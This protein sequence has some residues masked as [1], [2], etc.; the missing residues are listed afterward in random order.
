MLDKKMLTEMIASNLAP[1]LE[2]LDDKSVTE[3]MINPGGRVF[4]EA[5]GVLSA[6][7]VLISDLDVEKTIIAVGKYAG[8][9]PRRDSAAGIV[10]ASI[11]D[12]RF[13]GALPPVC[14][15]GSFISIRK[16]SDK[17][18]RPSMENL[19]A[20]NML[21][22]EQ[23]ERLEDLV[24]NQRKNLF[25]V[26]GTGSGKTT[27]LNAL[28][29]RLPAYERVLTIE[30]SRE[31][32][33]ELE[34]HFPMVANVD[35]GITARDLVKLMLRVRPDRLVLG[36]TRGDETYD[37]IRAFNSGHPGS[38]STIH[39]DSAEQGLAALEMMFQMSLPENARMS[40]T[41]MRQCIAASVNVVVFV[42]RSTV[43][44]DGV[45]KVV[46]KVTEICIVK[47]VVDGKYVLE[48]VA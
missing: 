2:W 34:N 47:G 39:A 33:L 24:L 40:D 22:Q 14:P 20:W 1:I 15:D 4:V 7:G 29:N 11:D 13:S 18:E 37:V 42:S 8:K 10:Y 9:N 6:K 5:A 26:G 30:D 38:I 48:N 46:R 3:I 36:E 44:K 43:K 41:V 19:I 25:I 16:H 31:I 23:A 28:L 35:K 21:T 17:S 27:L 45:A 32:H 12:L